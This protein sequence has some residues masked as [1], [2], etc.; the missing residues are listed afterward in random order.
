MACFCLFKG[1]ACCD[2]DKLQSL[3]LS[4]SEWKDSWGRVDVV[5]IESACNLVHREVLDHHYVILIIN[6]GACMM[7]HTTY[8]GSSQPAHCHGCNEWLT[9]RKRLTDVCKKCKE[10][11]EC[12][13]NNNLS[14][15][16]IRTIWQYNQHNNTIYIHIYTCTLLIA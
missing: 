11:I 5:W 3:Y 14:F 16:H 1:G 2:F 15:V 7:R 13:N 6:M 12:L 9:L 10:N 4:H 8:I